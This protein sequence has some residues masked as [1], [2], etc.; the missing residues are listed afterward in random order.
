MAGCNDRTA[1]SIQRWGFALIEVLISVTILSIVMLS[2]IS[3]VQSC[4]YVISE[5]KNYTKAMM[6]AKGKMNEF[7]LEKMRGADL[8]NE[9]V[10]EY[11]GFYYSRRT[12]PYTHPMLPF[13]VKM[14]EISVT[15]KSERKSSS[16]KISYIYAE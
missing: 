15:W 14:T 1:L 4:I 10:A 16:Y 11:P 3:G 12:S 13:Q 8:S 6:I 5:N 2:V 7:L 9:A